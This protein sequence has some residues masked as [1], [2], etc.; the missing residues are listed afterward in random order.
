[1]DA[2]ILNPKAANGSTAHGPK[3]PLII[4]PG[5]YLRWLSDEPDPHDLMLPFS[6][7]LMRMWPNVVNKPENDDHGVSLPSA[8]CSGQCCF[9]VFG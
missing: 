1:L 8:T 3:A 5:N 2:V 4:A 9:E 7:E 6:A